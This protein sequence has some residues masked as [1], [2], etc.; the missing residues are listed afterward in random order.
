VAACLSCGK[1]LPGKFPF[2]PFCGASLAAP[3]RAGEQRK[4]V[5][6][7]FCDITGSTQL[8]EETDAEALRALLARY[9]TDTSNG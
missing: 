8:G 5:T 6:L 3:P 1:E 4:T 7:L 2:C 9:Q